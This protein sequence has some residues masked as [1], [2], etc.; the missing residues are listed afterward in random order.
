MRAL[1]LP[2]H[3]AAANDRQALFIYLKKIWNL[4]KNGN[5]QLKAAPKSRLIKERIIFDSSL[6]YLKPKQQLILATLKKTYYHEV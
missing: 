6:F 1:P 4:A 5:W 2:P 3:Q